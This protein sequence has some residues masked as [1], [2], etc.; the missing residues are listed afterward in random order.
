MKTIRVTGKINEKGKLQIYMG[1]LNDFC[2]KNREKR[3][4]AT[5]TIMGESASQSL[6]GYYF[7]YVVPTI[8]QAMWENGD[9]RTLE[10]TDLYLRTISPIC[11]KEQMVGEKWEYELKTIHELTNKEL[12]EHINTIKQFGAEN[13]YVYINDPT[14][15]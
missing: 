6:K 14:E 8:R 9:R 1:E 5:F 15:L 2:N 13:F 7:S 11:R 3:V 10:D 12:I 4:L